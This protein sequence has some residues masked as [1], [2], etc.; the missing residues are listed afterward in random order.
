MFDFIEYSLFGLT[1]IGAPYVMHLGKHVKVDLLTASLPKTAAYGVNLLA[2]AISFLICF[3]FLI[4]SFRAAY[5][6]FVEEAMV[7]KTFEIKAWIPLVFV[8][9]MFGMLCISITRT[10]IDLIK[11]S[12]REL[13]ADDGDVT[14][15]RTDAL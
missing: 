14:A 3:V 10:F 6:S 12:E 7:F 8:P 11:N 2:T 13:T 15:V 5:G 4:F 1:M 9:F